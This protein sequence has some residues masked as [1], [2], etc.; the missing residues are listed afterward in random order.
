MNS[1]KAE[2]NLVNV[3]GKPQL[4][5]IIKTTWISTGILF[6]CSKNFHSSPEIP[7]R[8]AA[9]FKMEKLRLR[10]VPRSMLGPNSNNSSSP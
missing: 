3:K 4:F 2:E 5:G 1:F 9:H 10:A 8:Q 7:T 6:N